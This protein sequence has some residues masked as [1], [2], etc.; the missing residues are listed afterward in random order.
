MKKFALLF[1]KLLFY[2]IL[3][4]IISGLLSFQKQGEST[5]LIDKSPLASSYTS[6]V[7]DR[8]MSMQISLMGSTPAVFNGPF[9]RI[10]SYTGLA[11]YESLYPGISKTSPFKFFPE[12]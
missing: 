12:N 11:A 2:P 7:L 4:S 3:I 10:F 6:Q 1:I 9:V 5:V 8:W